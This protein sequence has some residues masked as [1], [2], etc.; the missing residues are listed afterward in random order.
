MGSSKYQ[1]EYLPAEVREV[2][3]TAILKDMVF[4][5]AEAYGACRL[6]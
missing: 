2:I 1:Q 4:I 5:V 6:Y 3:D